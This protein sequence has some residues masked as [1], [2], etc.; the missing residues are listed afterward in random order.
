MHMCGRDLWAGVENYAARLQ[1]R[2]VVRL[3]PD[4]HVWLS[5][6]LWSDLEHQRNTR[7]NGNGASGAHG[8][9]DL[10]PMTSR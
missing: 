9:L 2:N 3:T 8:W 7:N 6:M 10:A 1:P 5:D 4:E